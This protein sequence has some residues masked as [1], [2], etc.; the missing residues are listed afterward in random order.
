MQTNPNEDFKWI[1]QFVDH[2]SKFHVLFALTDNSASQ[3]AKN[4]CDR[5]FAYFGLPYIPQSDNGRE[6][7]TNIITET[8]GLWPGK[9]KIIRGRPRHSQSQGLV[10]QRNNTVETMIAARKDEERSNN[11]SKW[12]PEIQCKFSPSDSRLLPVLFNK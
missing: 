7:T 12:L 6:F 3:V 9:V 8:V 2:F 5:V 10:E 4:L 1:G 11:W